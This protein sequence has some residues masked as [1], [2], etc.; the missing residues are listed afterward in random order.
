MKF[1]VGLHQV[2]DA[3][4]FERSFISINRLRNRKSAFYV[5]DWIMDSGAFTEISK[6]GHYRHSVEEY[7]KQIERWR[8]IGN[9]QAAVTQDWMCEP[10]IVSKTGKSVHEHQKLTIDRYDEI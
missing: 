4:H 6:H 10:F 2:S 3:Q 5:M 9:M 8:H 7:V 1:Y